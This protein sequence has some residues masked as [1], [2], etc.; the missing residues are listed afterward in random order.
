MPLLRH[1]CL[2]VALTTTTLLAGCGIQPPPDP[3]AAL[4]DR[5]PIVVP[6]DFSKP[7]N[8]IVV[9]FRVVDSPAFERW[10][11][12]S[13]GYFLAVPQGKPGMRTRLPDIPSGNLEPTIAIRVRVERTDTP[14]PRR[15]PLQTLRFDRQMGTDLDPLK[16]DVS[17]HFSAADISWV[18]EQQGRLG[19]QFSR[20]Q[21]LTYFR[22]IATNAEPLAPG[23][24]R[25]TLEVLN[26]HNP[27]AG[28]EPKL[29]IAHQFSYN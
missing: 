9:D 7:G 16:N 17:R 27:F 20:D 11:S 15:V 3:D 22:S 13:I 10:D 8:T 6:F 26:G 19:E 4:P 14:Q 2:L 1:F 5:L 24:Y 23:R 18:S 21:Y 12:I 28:L 25:L 29:Y